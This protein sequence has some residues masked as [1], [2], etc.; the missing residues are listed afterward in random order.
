MWW[1]AASVAVARHRKHLKRYPG[2]WRR[3]DKTPLPR[4]ALNESS[5]R[6][7][8]AGGWRGGRRHPA[9]YEPRTG[10]AP[11]RQPSCYRFVAPPR[12]AAGLCDELVQS[13]YAG[14]IWQQAEHALRT[15]KRPSVHVLTSCGAHRFL[16]NWLCSVERANATRLKHVVVWA[17]DA[18]S[19]A[20]LGRSRPA[21]AD[22]AIN[23]SAWFGKDAVSYARFAALKAF[24]P[25][26]AATLGYDA[27]SQDADVVWRS[28]VLSFIAEAFGERR[29]GL[30]LTHNVRS[31]ACPNDVNGGFVYARAR[32]AGVADTLER[33]FGA[34]RNMVVP[35]VHKPTRRR[36]RGSNKTE[37]QPFLVAAAKDALYSKSLRCGYADDDAPRTPEGF[38]ERRYEITILDDRLFTSGKDR[39]STG[40]LLFHANHRSGWAAKC[41]ALR[42]AGA[43]HVANESGGLD[44]CDA[45][46]RPSHRGACAPD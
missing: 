10:G 30:L 32:S 18:C 36:P 5:L 25:L 37:N 2:E 35:N 43:L 45:D 14:R 19:Y 1:C 34:C 3:F 15:S 29:A 41:L 26:V 31:T 33:W 38:Y 24:M 9:C 16:E 12:E 44:V 11:R 7:L 21:L 28:D 27:L 42:A 8:V 6:A 4:D 22:R 39:N 40:G 13:V 23:A 20:A 17:A 46:P